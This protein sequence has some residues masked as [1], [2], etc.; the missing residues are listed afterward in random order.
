MNAMPEN[1]PTVLTASASRLGPIVGRR[2]NRRPSKAAPKSEKVNAAQSQAFDPSIPRADIQETS[3]TI[4][5]AVTRGK[6]DVR[7]QFARS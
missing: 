5:I 7:A 3:T 4:V 6:R 2:R 1:I